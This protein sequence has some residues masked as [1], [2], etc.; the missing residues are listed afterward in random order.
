MA[1]IAQCSS[2]YIEKRERKETRMESI[3]RA[4]R[5]RTRL[6]HLFQIDY[7][8]V[9]PG[10][11]W[12]STPALVAAV[13]NAGGLGILATGPLDADGTRRS[14]QQI[15]ALTDKPFGIGATLLM[16]GASENARVA[17]EEQVPVI[18]VSLGKADWIAKGAHEYGGFVLSTVTNSKHAA[19]AVA[20][21]ADALMCTGHEA[22]AHGGDVTSL[23]LINSLAAQFPDVP[24]VGAG[25]FANGRGLVAALALG[26]DGVAMGSRFAVTLESPL[27]STMKDAITK[28]SESD[29]LYGSNF[30][31]IPARVLKT[32]AAEQVMKRRPF[33]G[34]IVYRAFLAARQLQMPLWKVLPGLVTQYEKIFIVAQFGAA[35]E[36][37][38]A[39]TVDGNIEKGVQFVGQ[40]AGMIHDVPT[41]AEM[42]Q[43]IVRES[44]EASF[45]TSMLFH[46]EKA[47]DAVRQ[48]NAH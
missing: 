39:A 19:A 8:V 15:R 11:S 18:N 9:L 27:A 13:S 35:T 36:K 25:G 42:M 4:P 17:L 44:R 29:T 26:A 43:R 5:I 12:I 30:D 23:V 48:Q 41:V 10:M 2:L 28:S 3:I 34:T 45:S 16:P 31:G 6:T 37:I 40:S 46:D 7:P 21:G 32:P 24:I 33:L 38:M 22:A 14:I 1:A 20:A 47:S